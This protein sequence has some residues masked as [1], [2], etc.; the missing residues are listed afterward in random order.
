[1]SRAFC[2]Q[3]THRRGIH[4]PKA[5]GEINVELTLGYAAEEG[6]FPKEKQG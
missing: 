5:V 6:E 2:F 3:S 4:C 1:M